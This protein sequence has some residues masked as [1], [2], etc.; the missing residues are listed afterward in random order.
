MDVSMSSHFLSRHTYICP[1]ADQVVLL[2]LASENYLAIPMADARLLCGWVRDW[3]VAGPVTA[4]QPE[5]L[6]QLLAEGLLT[7]NSEHARIGTLTTAAC[8]PREALEDRKGIRVRIR[9]IDVFRFFVAVIAGSIAL[10]FVPLGK[11]VAHVRKRKT[12]AR[13]FDMDRALTLLVKYEHLYAW[14]FDRNDECL[15][16]SLYLLTFF[17]QHRLF[18]DWIFGVR[19]EPF[20]AHCWLQHGSVVIN[21]KVRSTA[22]LLPIMV[23]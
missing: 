14:F 7:G 17:A 5:I 20:L 19:P 9:L 15:R 13:A 21:D 23:V 4:E 22:C 16:N 18:P 3:P 6:K 2:D 12:H 8:L 1:G 10:R 11:I